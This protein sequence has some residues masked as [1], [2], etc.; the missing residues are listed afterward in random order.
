MTTR[1]MVLRQI[2]AERLKLLRSI[3]PE[4]GLAVSTLFHRISELE[5]LEASFDRVLQA[6]PLSPRGTE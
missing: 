1:E 3:T 5:G 2:V 4:N 6:P